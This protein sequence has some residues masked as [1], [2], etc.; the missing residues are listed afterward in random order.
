M[1]GRAFPHCIPKRVFC[2]LSRSFHPAF[3]CPHPSSL[4]SLACARLFSPSLAGASICTFPCPH[5]PFPSSPL[6]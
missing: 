3:P 6:P 1:K 5:R 4:P 2:P